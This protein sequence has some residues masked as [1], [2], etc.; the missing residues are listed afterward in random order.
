MQ[1]QSISCTIW[2]IGDGIVHQSISPSQLSDLPANPV[3]FPMALAR[4]AIHCLLLLAAAAAGRHGKPHCLMQQRE[5]FPI[6]SF[7]GVLAASSPP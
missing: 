2:R 1:K 4:N 5:L 3:Q 7:C 6:F